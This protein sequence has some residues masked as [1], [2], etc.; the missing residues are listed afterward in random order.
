MVEKPI[1][2]VIIDTQEQ[3]LKLLNE[4]RAGVKVMTLVIDEVKRNIESQANGI[5]I[6]ERKDYN[7]KLEKEKEQEETKNA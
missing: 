7:E 2:L 6:T 5:Y 3:I 4:M 1:D